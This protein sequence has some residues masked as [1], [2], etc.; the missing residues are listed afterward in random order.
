MSRILAYTSPARGHLFPLTPI[1]LELRDRG[2]DVAVRTLASEVPM[3]RGLGIDAQPIAPAI[4]G[5]VHED[6]RARTP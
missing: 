2:H 5:I 4:E 1:L 6:W 3:V